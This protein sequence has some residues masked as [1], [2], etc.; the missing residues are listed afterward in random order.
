MPFMDLTDVLC[1]PMTNDTFTVIRRQQSVGNNGVVAST[2][3]TIT[4]L[5]GVVAAVGNQSPV[6]DE[7]FRNQAKSIQV[8]TTFRLRPVTTQKG[9]DYMPDLVLWP[10]A[11]QFGM[12]AV[13]DYYM[14]QQISDYSRFGAGF[15]A[16]E[17]S[18]YDFV[19]QAPV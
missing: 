13:G 1:D 16:A 4:P 7:A 14:V 9:N 10:I 6:R 8:I 19:D 5:I 18:S 3:T 2:N 11:D 12:P 17:C 15:I